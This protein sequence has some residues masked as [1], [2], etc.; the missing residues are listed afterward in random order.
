MKDD[1]NKWKKER[2]LPSCP[3]SFAFLT[4]TIK[5]IMDSVLISR[6]NIMVEEKKEEGKQKEKNKIK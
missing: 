5:E 3:W 4:E 2:D 6:V 1:W